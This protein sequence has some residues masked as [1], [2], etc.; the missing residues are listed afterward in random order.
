M[1]LFKRKKPGTQADRQV[2]L[3]LLGDAMGRAEAEAAR[4]FADQCERVCTSAGK[5]AHLRHPVRGVLC[6]DMHDWPA[7]VWLPAPESLPLHHRCELA[8]RAADGEGEVA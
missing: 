6:S 7:S 1:G 2:S 4:P 8:A 5:T 3:G